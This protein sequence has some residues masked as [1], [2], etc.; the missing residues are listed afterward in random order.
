MKFPVPGHLY[1][2]PGGEHYVEWW[3]KGTTSGSDLSCLHVYVDNDLNNYFHD[4]ENEPTR[5]FLP[6]E[7]QSLRSTILLSS[8]LESIE[9]HFGYDEDA[10]GLELLTEAG[11]SSLASTILTAR[12][13]ALKLRNNPK[14]AID[15]ELDISFEDFF[16]S[17][18]NFAIT[19]CFLDHFAA[20]SKEIK[21]IFG[22]E[23]G[24][25][26]TDLLEFHMKPSPCLDRLLIY[27]NNLDTTFESRKIVDFLQKQ[28]R[29]S[30]FLLYTEPGAW[31]NWDLLSEDHVN[32]SLSLTNEGVTEKTILRG[33]YLGGQDISHEIYLPLVSD[34]LKKK[35]KR[36]AGKVLAGDFPPVV[37]VS[38]ITS[39]NGWETTAY[40]EIARSWDVICV[41]LAQEVLAS[42]TTTEAGVASITPHNQ[43]QTDEFDESCL[44][45]AYALVAQEVLASATAEAG[46]TPHK[47]QQTDESD[48]VLAQKIDSS[49]DA[50]CSKLKGNVGQELD[51]DGDD[52][53][54]DGKQG[55]TELV[56]HIILN[57]TGLMEAAGEVPPPHGARVLLQDI[58][59]TFRQLPP[60]ALG[61]VTQKWAERRN[62]EPTGP[63]D[64]DDFNKLLKK[65]FGELLGS[66]S[67]NLW[68]RHISE[69]ED[70]IPALDQ[71]QFDT[72]LELYA[73]CA[74]ACQNNKTQ[75]TSPSMAPVDE[76]EGD[77]DDRRDRKRCR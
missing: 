44:A 21:F 13:E 68:S 23:L 42:A 20:H 43:K 8:G 7:L 73:F 41:G 60:E 39:H 27:G 17:D 26:F 32:L 16:V 15:I 54:H 36:L 3:P 37:A 67:D 5:D 66:D 25:K 29:L 65:I 56:R 45:A 10:P 9:I 11:I 50:K 64:P 40:T 28:T 57:V 6:E 76:F 14:A 2:G 58:V 49:S 74:K 63:M 70:L 38:I 48:Y 30:D 53:R 18:D 51:L 34:R 12:T 46:I 33:R 4:D 61:I 22:G 31:Q 75:T 72:V 24:S 71:V 35:T 59:D 52:K 69:L 77:D 62:Q 1:F 55:E 19:K 47:K